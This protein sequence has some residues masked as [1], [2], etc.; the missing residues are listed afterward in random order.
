VEHEV[1]HERFFT[2]DHL[3][4]AAGLIQSLN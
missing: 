3:R 4:E 2:A 1:A